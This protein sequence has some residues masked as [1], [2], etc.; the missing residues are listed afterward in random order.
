MNR[1]LTLPN[2]CCQISRSLANIGIALT[3]IEFVEH[4]GFQIANQNRFRDGK[5]VRSFH[6]VKMC[7]VSHVFSYFP[8]SFRVMLTRCWTKNNYLQSFACGSCPL[9][10]TFSPSLISWYL[11]TVS[12]KHHCW[13]YKSNHQGIYFSTKYFP[14]PSEFCQNLATC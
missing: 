7:V 9:C 5:H 2:T 8:I 11:F 6:M 12:V 1:F 13:S 3:T 14:F 4:M 10:C